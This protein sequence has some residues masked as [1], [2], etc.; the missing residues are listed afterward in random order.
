VRRW[1]TSVG[2]AI[3][4]NASRNLSS[5][6]AF[7]WCLLCA[8]LLSPARVFVK[9]CLWSA[10]AAVCSS[11]SLLGRRVSVCI[12][13]FR[14]SL[15]CQLCLLSLPC[16]LRQRVV[17]MRSLVQFSCSALLLCASGAHAAAAADSSALSLAR[18]RA[19]EQ[20]Y[21]SL[22]ETLKEA[23]AKLEA[24]QCR[25]VS[26]C[27]A[28]R[29]LF[30]QASYAKH[31]T[32]LATAFQQ[33]AQDDKACSHLGGGCSTVPALCVQRA[34]EALLQSTIAKMTFLPVP[35][36]VEVGLRSSVSL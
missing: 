2:F 11:A 35:A 21:E 19:P 7:A 18:A 20:Q 36:L 4:A 27:A 25:C 28:R 34:C 33:H 10:S 3:A 16:A 29:A 30:S 15:S 24:S 22:A 14:G 8:C 31:G 6:F 5:A 1:L 23:G 26:E 12:E 32:D 13:L 17:A 9:P